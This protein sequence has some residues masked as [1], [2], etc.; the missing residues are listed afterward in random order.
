MTT[1]RDKAREAA[2]VGR[3]STTWSTARVAADT[4][5]D[6]WE[7]EVDRWKAHTLAL[8][9]VIDAMLASGAYTNT[10]RQIHDEAK[11][12]LRADRP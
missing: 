3:T 7:V 9:K 11:E 2:T 1:T 6:V 8:S 12:A 4:A 10:H 5:S